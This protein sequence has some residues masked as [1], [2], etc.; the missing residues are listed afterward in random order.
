MAT[1]FTLADARSSLNVHAAEKGDE[2]YQKYGPHIGWPELQR[3]LA[4]R[5]CVRYPCEIVF[6]SRQ[7]QLGEFAHP[8]PKGSRPEDGFAIQVHPF[9]MSQLDQVPLLVLYHL[10]QVNYGGFAGPDDAEQF[11]AHALG[12][13]PND[14]YT[15][16]CLLADQ[17]SSPAPD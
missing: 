4:D 3:I 8:V 11:G 14:Y 15:R 1:K 7:L 16:L 6:D 17:I 2:I 5:A 13:L 10:V 9:F 12:L